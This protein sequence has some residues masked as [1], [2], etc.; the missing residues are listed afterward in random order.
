[1]DALAHDIPDHW[2]EIVVTERIDAVVVLR[3]NPCWIEWHE[4]A[5]FAFADLCGNLQQR[6]H[7]FFGVIG[8][9]RVNVN[10]SHAHQ[11]VENSGTVERITEAVAF[12]RRFQLANRPAF[13]LV[14]GGAQRDPF[15]GHFLGYGFA[16]IAIFRPLAEFG[17]VWIPHEPQ[18]FPP[19]PFLR[20][21]TPFAAG[22]AGC[23]VHR[24]ADWRLVTGR[25]NT[26]RRRRHPHK[27]RPARRHP[28]Q[29]RQ[30]IVRDP[31][32]TRGQRRGRCRNRRRR[33]GRLPT[34]K[35]L[36]PSH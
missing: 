36:K 5:Q 7:Q 26:R 10:H 14:S 13:V 12:H 28:S 27:W 16:D 31:E 6:H 24:H 29:C 3:R 2:L 9:P 8:I 19:Q 20:P 17:E 30:C 11:A 32:W 33:G 21:Y 22:W 23:F 35:P 1:M 25:T 4:P 15:A 18:P 34:E